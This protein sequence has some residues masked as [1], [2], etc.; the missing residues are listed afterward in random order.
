MNRAAE[1]TVYIGGGI[2]R[3]YNGA[4]RMAVL[5]QEQKAKNA[6]L[7]NVNTPPIRNE[8][9]WVVMNADGSNGRSEPGVI[10]RAVPV[11]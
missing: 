6:I 9:S 5:Y 4:T 1:G 10:V 2:S 7:Q 8:K 3:F 11:S